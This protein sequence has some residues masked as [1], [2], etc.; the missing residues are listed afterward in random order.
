[1]ES[2]LSSWQL[3]LAAAAAV[4]FGFTLILLLRETLCK[5]AADSVRCLRRPISEV[6]LLVFAVGGL[7]QYGSTKGTNGNGR[8]M[9]SM[10]RR[11]AVSLAPAAVDMSDYSMPADFPP[12]TNLCFW[13]IERG[14]DSVA[15]GIA[16][17]E[18]M[19][20]VNDM[21]DL[22]GSGTL[23]SN[24]WTR[25]AE[26]AVGS[27]RSNAVVE[28]LFSDFPTNAMESAA[29]FQMASQ[30]DSDGDGLS[31]AEERLST[32]TDPS[33]PDT[34]G[35]GLNDGIECLIGTSPV[36]A[37][38]DGDGIADLVELGRTNEVTHGVALLTG[39]EI[40]TN[41]T[42]T[43]EFVSTG[44]VMC[45]D[46]AFSTPLTLG[47][48]SYDHISLDPNGI[49]YLCP[50]PAEGS[51][52]SSSFPDDYAQ[53]LS[54]V[55]DCILMP[56]WS[57]LNIQTGGFNGSEVTV[58]RLEERYVITYKNM[59]FDPTGFLD[60]V[61]PSLRAFVPLAVSMT[62]V[63]FQTILDPLSS[64]VEF[65]YE[66]G[67]FSF[68]GL[69]TQDYAKGRLAAVG[70][71]DRLGGSAADFGFGNPD[72]VASGMAIKTFL[73][74][75]SDPKSIDTDGDGV[76]DFDELAIGRDPNNPFDDSESRTGRIHLC[77]GDPS[78]THS[79]SYRVQISAVEGSGEG[80]RPA[81]REF[82]SP[83]G[84]VFD[85]SID[86]EKGWKYEVR[87][88]WED[89]ILDTPDYDYVIGF[90]SANP[91]VIIDD[92][93]CLRSCHVYGQLTT[94]FPAAGKVATINVLDFSFVTPAGDPETSPCSRF[95]VGQNEFTYNDETSKLSLSPRVRVLPVL[96][97]ELAESIQGRF[98][99]P[100]IEGATLAW[101]G[102]GGGIVTASTDEGFD[103]RPHTMFGAGAEYCGYP[104]HNSG[105]GRKTVTF[106][107]CGIMLKQDFEVF[108]PKFGK[109]HPPCSTCPGCSNWFY[110]WREGGVC[111]IPQDAC[112]AEATGAH[113][114]S[115]GWYRQGRIYLTDLA[116]GEEAANVDVRATFDI[117]HME[118]FVEKVP[119][120]AA[121]ADLYDIRPASE[122]ETG[123]R[124]YATQRV[125][126][127]ESIL[128]DHTL[129]TDYCGIGEVA[130][131]VAHE[132][133]HGR[134]K[135]ERDR[136]EAITGEHPFP[137]E[138]DWRIY[139]IDSKEYAEKEMRCYESE[140]L[141][142]DLDE[143]FGDGVY[144]GGERDDN[145][146]LGTRSDVNR[147]DTFNLAEKFGSVYRGYGDEEVRCRIAEKQNFEGRY[148]V[149][150][151]WSNPGCQH[152]LPYGP[153][154]GGAE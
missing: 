77:F 57:R 42:A 31:D 24:G 139:G 138:Q 73:S 45:V 153:K 66:I 51:I 8:A 30:E 90:G 58:R 110:Y 17:P 2:V 43:A 16:W 9:M 19:T 145:G 20:F 94:D 4:F 107:S 102:G 5:F 134:I 114:S 69:S 85:E 32:G 87:M 12:A 125:V 95:G 72:A 67:G 143:D 108:F 148:V 122:G 126:R 116:A 154:K 142:S 133:C 37:D 79:E 44:R 27:A 98:T 109:N 70:V 7:V 91:W 63:S 150:A 71:R 26:V 64:T 38:T 132:N 22:F 36:S 29:F 33:D 47:G 81:D 61:D 146:Y 101:D 10:P 59:R 151:D 65:R 23:R 1:M 21:L 28:V 41:L 111:S 34:D 147:R 54:R 144:D 123:Y 68:G 56:Y 52:P 137:S 75:G 129:G 100:Q 50:A 53:V 55:G 115:S 103:E 92:S 35:D 60:V 25:V 105:F 96:D 127:I 18:G 99:L 13:G 136:Q 40:L 118:F 84:A 152:E 117:V 14:A 6:L 106:E 124:Y 141:H 120:A 39:G 3:D 88:S 74:S 83:T 149:D 93:D 119:Y 78:N 104:T 11:V 89:S 82:V 113:A 49:V 62:P 135:E 80:G 112:W 15:F 76:N 131:T 48:A 46:F 140:Y 121:D 97:D 128:E 86:L 130:V